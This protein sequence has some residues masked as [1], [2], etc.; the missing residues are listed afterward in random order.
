MNYNDIAYLIH[1]LTPADS[2]GIYFG[3]GSNDE[4]HLYPGNISFKDSLDLLGIAYEFYDHA[5]GHAMPPGFIQGSLVFL[6]SLLSPPLLMT[7]A[8]PSRF[9]AKMNIYPNPCS[10]HLTIVYDTENQWDI[11]Y[12]ILNIHGENLTGAVRVHT[13][14]GTNQIA[15]DL[16]VHP[17]GIYFIRID[18]GKQMYTQKVIKRK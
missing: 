13:F 17:A 12:Q 5:G 9:D 6:D 14:P 1:D 7:S 2:V 11:Q 16:S 10:D 18:A 8:I 15:L 4:W 3:C